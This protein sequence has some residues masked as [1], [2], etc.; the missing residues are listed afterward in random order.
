MQIN[1]LLINYRMDG[2]KNKNRDKFILYIDFKYAF[3]TVSHEGLFN[4]LLSIGINSRIIS[5]I[6]LIF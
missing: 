3:D 4:N 5:T 6:R 2:N 1:R